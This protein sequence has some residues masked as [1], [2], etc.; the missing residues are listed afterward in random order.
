MAST[1]TLFSRLFTGP[2][3]TTYVPKQNLCTSWGSSKEYVSAESSLEK[4]NSNNGLLFASFS[5]P[6]DEDDHRKSL[7]VDDKKK[8]KT[9]SKT[10]GQ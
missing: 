9:L 10:A 7:A 8:K 4:E 6:D 5:R 1:T 2:I 3:K